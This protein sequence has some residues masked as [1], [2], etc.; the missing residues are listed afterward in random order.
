MLIVQAT[1]LLLT[2]AAL[3]FAFQAIRQRRTGLPT[4][5]SFPTVL[6]LVLVGW[7]TTEVISDAFGTSLGMPGKWTHL[8][9]MVLL[10][11]AVTMQLNR[12]RKEPGRP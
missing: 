12:A 8:G 4:A 9:V 7:I 6:L 11:A 5:A 3:V 1:L 2:L 10:S